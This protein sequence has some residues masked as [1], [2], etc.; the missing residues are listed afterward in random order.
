M[1]MKDWVNHVDNVLQ[2]TGEDVLQGHGRVSREQ[3]DEKVDIEYKKY[4]Q[5]TLTQVERDYMEEIK[6]LEQMGKN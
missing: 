1:T 3:A 5:K 4:R 2:A 6:K